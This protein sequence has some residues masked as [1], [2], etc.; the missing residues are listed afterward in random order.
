MPSMSPRWRARSPSSSFPDEVYNRGLRVIT[1]INRADQQ[2]AYLAL[3][4]GVMDYDRRHGYRGA[5]AYVDMT[6]IDSNQDEALEE[7]LS[8]YYDSDDLLPAIVLEAGPKLVRAY[9]RGGEVL[10]IGDDGLKFAARM[11]DDKAAPNKRIRRG[12]VIRVQK[13]DKGWQILQLPEVEAAFVAASPVDG[14]I[15]AMVG[16]FDFN[17]NKFNRVTQAWRQPGSSFKP[18]IYSGLARE[19]LIRRHR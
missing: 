1:T 15:R 19:G 16:G 17:R 18:F 2:A 8:D 7:H 3:R 11:L 5:E 9:L 12:A 4:R 14:A 6:G 13:A 10:K